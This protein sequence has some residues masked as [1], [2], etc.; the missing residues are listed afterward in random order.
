MKYLSTRNKRL[1][2]NPADAVF[3][4]LP[5]DNGLYIPEHIPQLDPGLIRKMPTLSLPEV[6]FHVLSLFF[7]DIPEVELKAI[8]GKA[9]SFEIPL[10]RVDN[11]AFS[12]ELFHG[13]TLAFKDVGAG[14]LAGCLNYYAQNSSKIVKVLVATSGD[15]GSAVA[16]GFIGNENIDVT[17]LY[18]KGRISDFQEKQMTTLGKNITAIAVNGNFDDCQQMVKKAFL[19]KDLR[20]QL[21]LTSA[22]SIN[23]ARLLAQSVYYFW[24]WTQ[25]TEESEPIISV[26]CGNLGNLTAGII[27]KK[28]GLPI[29][30]FIASNNINRT[31]TEY[32]ETGNYSPTESIST[33]SNAMDVGDPSNFQRIESIYSK[34]TEQLSHDISAYSYSDK[35]TTRFYCY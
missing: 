20:N 4:S 13:P 32:L 25:W 12:L 17:I 35:E 16:N 18:P 9:L 26:P 34:D 3:R 27:A 1:K 29:R 2:V 8:V 7:T 11:K 19:D 14:F 10:K 30:H 23:I 21:L 5:E 24:A 31:F 22:N 15:T 6:G 28:M 33:V